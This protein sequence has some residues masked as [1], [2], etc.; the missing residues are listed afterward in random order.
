MA[1]QATSAKQPYA[2]PKLDSYSSEEILRLLGPAL[3]VY[4]P[5]P[6]GP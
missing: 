6:G 1:K 3:A 2:A 4:G 5:G